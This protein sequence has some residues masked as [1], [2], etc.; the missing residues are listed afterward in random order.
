MGYS[1]T[2]LSSGSDD[3]PFSV[4]EGDREVIEDAKADDIFI[5][6][7][8]DKSGCGLKRA[9]VDDTSIYRGLYLAAIGKC[10]ELIPV[11]RLS[12]KKIRRHRDASVKAGIQ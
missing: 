3:Y 5:S 7:S 1:R 8:D 10:P 2:A 4:I 9:Y 11:G 6:E 12:F